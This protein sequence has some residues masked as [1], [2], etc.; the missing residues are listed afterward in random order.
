[1]RFIGSGSPPPAWHRFERAWAVPYIA[2]MNDK[3]LILALGDSLTAG[4]GLA[5]A[6]GF[7]RRL[8]ALLRARWPDATVHNAGISGD[9]SAGGLARL[10]RLLSNLVRKPHLAIVE[11]GANDALRFIDP[12][13]TYANLDAILRELSR[14]GIRT[15]IAGMV[16]PRLLGGF[17]QAHNAIYPALAA[18][19]GA[20]LYPFFLEGV[21]GQR[22]LTLADGIHPNATAVDMVAR[23]IL[24]HVAR[25]LE[26]ELG[27][28]AA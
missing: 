6:E 28:L 14:C 25:E 13:L 23:S 5:P 11:L 26:A 2:S 15:L 10:P 9:T 22:G 1:M 17:A 27:V 19:H 16:V 18:A 3:P 24:L 7:T 20:T 12:R 8:E 4:Y 21:V